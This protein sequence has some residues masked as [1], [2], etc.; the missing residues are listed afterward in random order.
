MTYFVHIQEGEGGDDARPGM[1]PRVRSGEPHNRRVWLREKR[2]K[3]FHPADADP[4]TNCFHFDTKV[5]RPIVSAPIVIKR[6]QFHQFRHYSFL[7]SVFTNIFFIRI[8]PDTGYWRKRCK[9]AENKNN[10]GDPRCL[11]LWL[12]WSCFENK[13]IFVP[14]SDH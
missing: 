13:P 1:N 10:A 14:N 3:R 8:Y 12:K 11:K 2:V 4:K 9:A 7:A 6:M 5:K